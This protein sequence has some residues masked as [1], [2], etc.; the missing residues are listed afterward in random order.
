[1]RPD[2]DT[3]APVSA[4]RAATRGRSPVRPSVEEDQARRNLRIFLNERMGGAKTQR[5]GVAPHHRHGAGAQQ[6]EHHQKDAAE[7]DAQSLVPTQIAH[8]AGSRFGAA[9]AGCGRFAHIDRSV[10]QVTG[11]AANLPWTVWPIRAPPISYPK[12]SNALASSD[13]QAL[14]QAGSQ[15]N[16]TVQAL[17]P[18][19]PE[20][21]ASMLPGKVCATGQPGAV[22]VINT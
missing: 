4:E 17:T 20:T 7:L 18:S 13:M 21:V 16:S 9:H 15:V 22:R 14:V 3:E 6:Q 1:M 11:P 10:S 12:F 2:A 5:D 19:V 8:H